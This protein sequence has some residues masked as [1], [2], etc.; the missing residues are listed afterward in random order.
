[1]EPDVASHAQESPWVILVPLIGLAIPSIVAGGILIGPMLF[2][3]QH[4]LGDSVFVLPEYN[5]LQTLADEFHGA[6]KM[7][8]E[9]PTTVSFWLAMAGIFTAWF[10]NAGFTQYT[11]MLKKRFSF[12][13]WIM[14]RKYGFDDFNQLV[15][16]R[17]TRKLGNFFYVFLDLAVIDGVFVN[18]SGK[19]IRWFAAFSRQM[20]TGYLYH[21][22]FVMILGLVV[23]LGWLMLGF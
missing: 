9:A 17:G 11:E 13:Y 6:T 15:F 23:F 18:G 1:M 5:V 2:Q 8:L 12:I 22:A 7:A 21:Y 10:F 20:Q 14:V 19:L 4:L 3:T 16:V